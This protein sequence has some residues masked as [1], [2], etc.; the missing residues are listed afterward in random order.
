MVMVDTLISARWIVPIIPENQILENHSLIIHEGRIKAILPTTDALQQYQ[1]KKQVNVK[2]HALMPGLVNAHAHSPM[3][4][5]RGLADDLPLMEWLQNHI[6]PA[7]QAIINEESMAD[8]TRLAALE[9]IRGG[10]TCFAENYFFHDITAKVI[11]EIGIRCSVGLLIIQVPTA[12][13]KDEHEYFNKAQASLKSTPKHPLLHWSIA[14]HSP[15]MVSDF[16]LRQCQQIAEEFDIP[17]H[18][19]LH[20]SESEIQQILEKNKKRPIAH[21][22]DLG[23][24]TPRLVG[25]HM[26]QLNDDDIAMISEA[27]VHIVHCPKSNMKLGN[28][29]TKVTALLKR[30][31]NVAIGTDG[32]ASNNALDMFEELRTAALMAK[33]QSSDVTS[34]PAATAL[35]MATYNG[36][37]AFGLEKEIGSLEVGKAADVIAVDLSH[38]FTQ[39]IY[40]PISHLAYAVNRLQVS[41]V[42][43]AGKHLLE[44]GEFTSIDVNAIINKASGWMEKAK[45]FSSRASSQVLNS[46]LT[47]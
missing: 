29:L 46:S 44:R 6:W 37:K 1:P 5:F 8:G 2:N 41:D 25:V 23:L 38:Y 30:G 31:L 11:T 45:P 40:N 20:E 3:T 13:A 16:A 21:L 4:L 27:G 22:A 12:W 35:K 18:L 43:I 15:Y 7:E 17:I 42:W 28:G 14:P 36:A 47:V 9:M 10:T 24:L 34:L 19:H 32:A 33:V 39:P 26:V